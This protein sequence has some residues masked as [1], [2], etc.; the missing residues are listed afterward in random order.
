MGDFFVFIVLYDFFDLFVFFELS[1][2]P[3]LE[4]FLCLALTVRAKEV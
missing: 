1:W 3:T 4:A 2:E